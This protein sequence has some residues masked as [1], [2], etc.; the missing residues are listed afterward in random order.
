MYAVSTHHLLGALT[1]ANQISLIANAVVVDVGPEINIFNDSESNCGGCPYG[2][3]YVSGSLK[4]SGGSYST[5]ITI[6]DHQA[7]FTIIEIILV[8]SICQVSYCSNCTTAVDCYQCFTPYYL[9]L[10]Q[11]V[12]QCDTGFYLYGRV[13]LLTCP[14]ATYTQTS[15]YLCLQCISPCSTC[16]SPT[17]CLSC[18]SG[19]YL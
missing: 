17:L 13:C 11:C 5:N 4:Y 3:K 15:S 18:M 19:Y 2:E 14:I 1:N 8:H 10:A 7:Q 9:Q 12:N 6:T 16:S